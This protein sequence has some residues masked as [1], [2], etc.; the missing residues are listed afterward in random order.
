MMMRRRALLITS[1]SGLCAPLLAQE[2]LLLELNQASRAELESLPGL[3]VQLVE[4]LL[5]AR[6]NA[7]F[8]NWADLRQRVRGIGPS[9]AKKLSALGLRVNGQAYVD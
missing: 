1:L 8:S 9:S 6:A 3:G 2:K 7:P 4:R 5:T